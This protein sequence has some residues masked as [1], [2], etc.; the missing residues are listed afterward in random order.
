MAGIPGNKQNNTGRE[1]NATATLGQEFYPTPSHVIETM[2]APY[3]KTSRNGSIY[4]PHKKR[5]D[6]SAGNGRIADRLKA[7]SIGSSPVYCY[8]IDLELRMILSGKGHAVIGSNFLDFSDPINR[9]DLIAM[10]P[11]FSQGAKHVLHAWNH[12]LGDGGDLVALVNA[13]TLRNLF[14]KERE[15]LTALIDAHGSVEYLGPV[16]AKSENPTNVDVALIRLHKPK[17]ESN[18]LFEGGSFSSRNLDFERSEFAENPLACADVIQSLVAQYNAAI[19]AL[20]AQD[21]AERQLA[22]FLEHTDKSNC[23]DSLRSLNLAKDQHP[24]DR[25]GETI[26]QIFWDTLFKHSKLASRTTSSFQKK[27][28][29]FRRD[30][31][32]DFNEQNIHE[33]LGLFF[34]NAGAIMESALLEVFDKATGFHEKNKIHHEG[35]KTNK[36]W[37]LTRKVIYPHGVSY[38]PHWWGFRLWDPAFLDD[39]DRVVCWIAGKRIENI[40]TIRSALEYRIKRINNREQSHSDICESEFFTMRMFKKGTLHIVFR[41]ETL[42]AEFNRRAAVGKKWIG[43]KGF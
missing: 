30:L 4:L 37:K 14:S 24:L 3:L 8:E 17:A 25:R 43:G 20:I 27:F 38:D 9:F 19:Q 41:D 21:K 31:K 6:P 10:N 42:L 13:E 39:L 12:A 7:L 34:Q 2:I 40:T 5:L 1:M 33:V 18:D 23:Y 28:A 29:E 22:F 35:W 32:L 11:P 36:G 15:I 16:F 26:R